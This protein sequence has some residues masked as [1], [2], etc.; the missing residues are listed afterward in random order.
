MAGDSNKL[1]HSELC[2]IAEAWLLK[3][4]RCRVAIA[5]PACWAATAFRILQGRIMNSNLRKEIA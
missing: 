1:K 3:G 2:K 5:E 4:N